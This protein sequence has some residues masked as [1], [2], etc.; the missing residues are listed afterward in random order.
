MTTTLD[1]RTLDLAAIL[2]DQER[3]IRAAHERLHGCGIWQTW[4]QPG[5]SPSG[6]PE[7]WRGRGC[8]EHRVMFDIRHGRAGA[9]TEA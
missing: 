9:T 2:A 3:R 5:R 6:R 4:E 8:P 7:T 1:G